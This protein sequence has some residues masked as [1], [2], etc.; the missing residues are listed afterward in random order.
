MK[1]NKKRLDC[2]IFEKTVSFLQVKLNSSV[3]SSASSILQ[4]RVRIPSTQ[5]LHYL[6]ATTICH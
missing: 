4:S 5:Y 1:I 3:D 2:P 6:I